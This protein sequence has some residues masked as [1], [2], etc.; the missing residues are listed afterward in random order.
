[1]RKLIAILV[2]AGLC[3]VLSAK[4]EIKLNSAEIKKLNIFFSNFSEAYVPNFDENTLND[5]I[6]LKF[7]IRHVYINKFSILKDSH[8]HLLKVVPMG[9]VDAAT[10]KYF[11]K[12]IKSNRKKEF[13]A[14]V[15]DSDSNVFSRISSLHDNNDCTYTA[16]GLI[17]SGVSGLLIDPYEP[18]TDL[19][20]QNGDFTA[21]AD[22]V[23]VIKKSETNHTRYI[24]LKYEVTSR[25]PIEDTF[26]E[27][28]PTNKVLSNNE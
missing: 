13:F 15:A 24:I 23:A 21:D 10:E 26:N 5:D 20:N 22:F 28:S 14:P 25:Y 7:G 8:D 9:L 19:D 1:M 3:A 6:L 27:D 18:S 4:S 16:R 17:Y 12:K 11:G 2:F